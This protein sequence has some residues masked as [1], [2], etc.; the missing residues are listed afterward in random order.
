LA[1]HN[2]VLAVLVYDPTGVQFPVAGPMEA[3]DGVGR[4]AIPN[5]AQF[6]KRF[7]A[8]FRDRC[9]QIRERLRAIRIPILPICTHEPVTDQVVA[10]L[11]GRR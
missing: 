5:E 6:A 8:E 3:T 9:D 1:A 4:M 11:G 7:E 2:D 10:A